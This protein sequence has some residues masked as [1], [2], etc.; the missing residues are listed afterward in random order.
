M[1]TAA[2]IHI[3]TALTNISVAYMQS[4]T[5]FIADKVFPVVPVQK[6]SDRYYVYSKEDWFRDE[7]EERARATESA[8][9]DYDIDNTP[10]YFARKYAYHKDVTEEDRANADSVLNP[11]QDA[12]DFVSHKL[13]IKREVLWASKY[14]VSGVWGTT[15]TGVAS[16]PTAGQF[17]QWNIP[18]TSHPIEDIDNA[19]TSIMSL[20]GYKPNVLVLGP[21]VYKA[22]KNH[23]DILERIK[24]TQR[25]L[26]TTEILA[27]LFDVERVLVA[28][29]VKNS[30]NKGGAD[31]TD[32][33][34]GNGALLC[35]AAPRPALKTPSAGYTFAW[36]GLL[37][38]GAY[39]NRIVRIDMPHLGIGTERIEGE[40]A[41]DQKI[42]AA[43]LGVYFTSA[44]KVS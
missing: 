17:V 32:F 38:A 24:Y 16:S 33:I 9:G 26:I 19:Q 6:Q 34:Y 36:T 13:L 42:I 35:Y 25:G 2:Q 11:D 14:F 8:G 30:S 39:G 18:S 21:R 28:E 44:L 23:A 4:E 31:A 5:K 7:A 29:A 20:T 37:G 22:L 12:T 40:M 27:A 3:D 10:S 43:D 41:F 1:P 15:L